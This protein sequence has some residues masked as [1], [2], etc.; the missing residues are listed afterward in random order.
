M[1][2]TTSVVR[3]GHGR[4]DRRVPLRRAAAVVAWVFLWLAVPAVEGQ[5]KGAYRTNAR[6]V[7]PAIERALRLKPDVA[8][9]L[10]N[11]WDRLTP[12]DLRPTW[13]RSPS[14][15]HLGEPSIAKLL[16][17][18][19]L[20]VQL[21]RRGPGSF[22]S[23]RVGPFTS[24]EQL[25]PA[26]LPPDL[27]R[28]LERTVWSNFRQLEV[29]DQLKARELRELEPRPTLT[30]LFRPPAESELQTF[31]RQAD[32]SDYQQVAQAFDPNVRVKVMELQEPAE[33]V[34]LFGLRPDGS[35]ASAIGH[36]YT[37]C[38][39]TARADEIGP[40]LSRWV[41]GSRLALPP[42]N[43]QTELARVR[44]PAGTRVLVGAVADNFANDLG[45]PKQGGNVQIFVP[46]VQ[47]FRYQ[48]YRFV[49]S[50]SMPDDI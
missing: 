31:L 6:L 37:C 18:G 44:V 41:D 16:A 25:K 29:V 5:Y 8:R 42:N 4:R 48:A 39:H 49:T 47:A 36:W 7:R 46:R 12:D 3:Q 40:G 27:T 10:G 32:V 17:Q 30:P 24:A 35:G 50:G 19:G 38:T 34:R 22:L 14:G 15:L 23:L 20:D 45:E 21:Q 2:R 43:P 26:P 1:A 9:R 11:R 33:L 28:L 13:Q